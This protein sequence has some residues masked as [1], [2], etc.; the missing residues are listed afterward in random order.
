MNQRSASNAAKAP[1]LTRLARDS[2]ANTMAI[3]AISLVPLS[4]LVGSGVDTA[5]MYVVKSRLQQACDAGVLAGRKFMGTGGGTTLDANAKLQAETFFAN[6]FNSGWF[7]TRD[8]AFTP[9]KTDNQRVAA[10]AVTTVPMTITRMFKAPDVTISVACEAQFDVADSDVM[11]VLDTTGSMACGATDPSSCGQSVVS[12][13]RPDGTTGY[14]VS[15][16]GN[17]RMKALREAVLVF[18]DTVATNADPTTNVRY[19]FVPY[20]STVNVGHALPSTS[21]VNSWTYSSRRWIGDAN[22]GSASNTR[23]SGYNRAQCDALA[24]RSPATGYD[25]NWQAVV[26]TATHRASDNTCLR[27]RQTVIPNYRFDFF[28]TDVS[29]YKRGDAVQDPSKLWSSPNRWQG[30]IEERDT[31]ARTSFND[32]NNLPFD[33]QIDLAPANDAQ[34]WRPMWPEQIYY[35][36]NR[37]PTTG[38]GGTNIGGDVNYLRSGYVSCGKPVQRLRKMARTE[39]Y[40][41]VYARDFTPQ[42]G[43]YHDT[44]MIWGARMIAPNGIFASDT[45]AWPGR[46]A[47]QRHIIF[48]TDGEMAPNADIYGM[49]AHERAD[50][51]VSGGSLGDLTNRHNA[52][53]RAV[54]EAAKARDISVWVIAFGSSLNDDLRACASTPARAFFAGTDEELKERFRE[55]AKQV[56]MLRLSK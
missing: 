27:S 21:I 19:G 23:L 20:T 11:F 16:K 6:N 10:T 25:G 38:T 39:V 26:T 22:S 36:A 15:E 46:D 42:G 50:Q 4:V 3:M 12:Y 49:Y 35:R 32:L 40:D 55:I 31:E 24:G 8:T 2:S 56:A 41:Y 43:T 52:R 30:C 47:P 29:A 18:Y 48:M 28:D 54:C 7:G 53:F 44:G 9:A 14:N 17:S 37:N 33:L 34:R 5:R 45:A 13:N 51:R 1:F